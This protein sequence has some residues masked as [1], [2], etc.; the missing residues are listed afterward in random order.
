MSTGAAEAINAALM[1][2]LGAFTDQAVTTTTA[3]TTTT[4]DKT[5]VSAAAAAAV[6]DGS[7]ARAPT[8]HTHDRG[9]RVVVSA[10]I[11]QLS[12]GIVGSGQ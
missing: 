2:N 6:S 4:E 9:D 10:S 3:A 12:G 8:E 11:R 1:S 7:V 5:V